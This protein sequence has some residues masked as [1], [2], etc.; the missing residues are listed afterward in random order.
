MYSIIELTFLIVLPAPSIKMLKSIPHSPLHTTP[1]ARSPQILLITEHIQVIH[2]LK[3]YKAS[4]WYSLMTIRHHCITTSVFMKYP[5]YD[6]L[7]KLSVLILTSPPRK[8]PQKNPS[9]IAALYLETRNAS[10]CLK[11]NSK[12]LAFTCQLSLVKIKMI[13]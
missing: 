8:G 9:T 2:T 12:T 11:V 5:R 6:S 13:F 10:F 1:L 4:H 3:S 7:M